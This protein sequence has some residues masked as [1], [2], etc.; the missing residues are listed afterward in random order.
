MAAAYARKT[1]KTMVRD[2]NKL[3]NMELMERTKEGVR[4]KREV[5]LAFLPARKFN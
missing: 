4:A 1:R 2:V 5:I 3:I